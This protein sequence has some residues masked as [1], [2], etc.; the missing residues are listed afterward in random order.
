MKRFVVLLAAACGHPAATSSR[1]TLAEPA[2][3]AATA[4]APACY[5]GTSK[6]AGQ[7]VHSVVRRTLDPRNQQ[8][9][10]DV[11]R[12]DAGDVKA[13]RVVMTVSGNS[14][15]LA[16]AGGQ[17]S[18]TGKL[19]G[20]SWAWTQWESTTAQQV[21]GATLEVESHEEL[22]PTGL[23]GRKAIKQGDKIIATTVEELTT[24]D[25]AQWDTA[26][27]ALSTPVLD[28]ALCERSCQRFA[29]IKFVAAN[30]DEIAKLPADK[31]E[32]AIQQK[33][34]ELEGKL[35]AGLPT[36]VQ[37]CRAANN[38]QQTACF[39]RAESPQDLAA[40]EK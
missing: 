9:V 14:F 2:A 1:P 12:G 7:L 29:T 6:G 19:I 11:V 26:R 36:C 24:I 22:T 8:I 4:P 10:E 34:R 27:K 18:G 32:A 21:N 13:F 37:Q 20:P 5:Q 28:D 17:F 15:T 16:E 39:A 35:Q 3:A 38:V 33:T 23:L 25:C 40:C 30:Q 31:R